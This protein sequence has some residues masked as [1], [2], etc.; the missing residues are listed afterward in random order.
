MTPHATW[1]RLLAPAIAAVCLMLG[2]SA[3]ASAATTPCPQ[4]FGSFSAGNWPSA[5]WRPY[6]P[7][8]PFNEEL[9]ANPRLAPDSSGVVADLEHY[10]NTFNRDGRF[11]FDSDG[12][13]GVFYSQPSDPVV[14]I[15]CTYNWGPSTCQ[16]SNG[17]VVDGMK[18][19]LPSGALPQSGA[20]QH[21]TV[22]DQADGVEYD[23]DQASVSGNTLTVWAGGQIPIGADSGTG[24][25]VPGTAAGFSVMAGLIR[26]PELAA[27]SINHALAIS[28]PCTEGS[29]W[30]AARANGLGCGDAGQW[31][32]NGTSA[33]ALGT[34]FQLNMSDARIAAFHAP[35]WERAIM[36]AMAHYGL[37]VNDTNGGGDNALEI[38]KESDQTYTSVGGRPEMSDL[39]HQLGGRY[40]GSQSGWTV[41]G[42][43]IPVAALRV[44]DPCVQRGTCP[45]G[46]ETFASAARAKLLKNCRAL[47]R[48]R[49]KHRRVRMPAR[50]TRAL[51]ASKRA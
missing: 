11:E 12:R 49:R 16:G 27:G 1:L 35:A 14:K 31:P 7:T 9:P 19:H 39:L 38:E 30:P 15:H 24:L 45:G 26:A 6:G 34:L 42:R 28:I 36:T 48:A 47:D 4:D 29:V 41:S 5:C 46:S 8:S 51:S 2:G 23:F 10:G 40:Q 17:V 22:I 25:G 44:I 50:C 43:A 32:S 20:D 3:T 13:D 21:M 37:Y 18:L 33:P